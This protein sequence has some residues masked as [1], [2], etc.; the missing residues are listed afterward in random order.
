MKALIL[1]LLLTGCSTLE[2]VH[3]PL[4]C[5]L[6]PA[7]TVSFTNDEI[8]QTPDSVVDKFKERSDQLKARIQ[9]VCK[10]IK[11]HNFAHEN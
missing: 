10:D 4:D 7:S 11:A 8:E 3:V 1:L 6:I 2:I 9:T 5:R